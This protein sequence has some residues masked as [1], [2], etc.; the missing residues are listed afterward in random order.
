MIYFADVA[1]ASVLAVIQ[2]GPSCTTS[3]DICIKMFTDVWILL[4]VAY[5]VCVIKF[6]KFSNA[7]K[8]TYLQLRMHSFQYEFTGYNYYV[9]KG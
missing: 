5:N 1:A 9:A 7:I 3:T 6:R 4:H 8:A 2:K